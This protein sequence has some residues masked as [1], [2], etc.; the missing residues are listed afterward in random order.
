MAWRRSSKL[1]RVEAQRFAKTKAPR[2]GLRET[3]TAGSSCHIPAAVKR[4]VCERDGNRCGF[5]DATG[6]RCAERHR[7]EFHHLQPWGR[8]GNHSPENLSLRCKAHNMHQ[9]ELDYGQEKMERY[10][11]SRWKGG[12]S[13]PAAIYACSR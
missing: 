10:R 6:K 1:Q 4:A 7:L 2:R 5:V 12:V 11:R 9:A 8:N 3:D 13:E